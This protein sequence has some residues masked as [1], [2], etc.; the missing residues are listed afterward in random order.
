MTAEELKEQKKY[1]MMQRVAANVVMPQFARSEVRSLDKGT[2]TLFARVVDKLSAL[3]EFASFSRDAVADVV[4]KTLTR[5]LQMSDL[6][7]NFN[8]TTWFSKPN[9]Y[10]SYV[11]MYAK[12][13]FVGKDADGNPV[14][15]LLPDTKITQNPVQSRV[16]AD[17]RV[18]FGTNMQHPEQLTQRSGVARI[19]STGG[20]MK[21]ITGADGK[22]FWHIKNGQFNRKAKQVFAALNYG[23]RP[24]G[25]APKYGK[26][27]LILKPDLKRNAIYYMGDTFDHEDASNRLTYGTLAGA[28]LTEHQHVVQD[29]LNACYF[30]LPLRDEEGEGEKGSKLFEAHIFGPVSFAHEVARMRIAESEIV[31]KA[32]ETNIKAFRKKFNIPT[33]RVKEDCPWG[34]EVGEEW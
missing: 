9:E 25:S 14:L 7:I 13:A 26:S 32:V 20:E 3:P 27:V 23:R 5:R 22:S 29:L 30:L 21:K 4:S 18:T 34:K 31:N 6:T 1:E 8:A 17:E 12:D 15:G 16:A 19:M 33:F 2:A 11:Q 24:G 10:T 28:F